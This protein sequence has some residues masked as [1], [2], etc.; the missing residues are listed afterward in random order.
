MFLY[1]FLTS[2]AVKSILPSLCEA[3][4]YPNLRI[5]EYLAISVPSPSPDEQSAIAAT[6]SEMGAEIT[7]LE[8]TVQ[9]YRKVKT[10]MMHSLLTGKIRLAV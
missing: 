2:H 9:K 7:L 3:S 1:Y 5:P 6:I 8:K 10:G 4:T